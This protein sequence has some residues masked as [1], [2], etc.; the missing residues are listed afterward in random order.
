MPLI[1]SVWVRN[2]KNQTKGLGK[3]PPLRGQQYIQQGKCAQESLFF[4]WIVSKRQAG[5]K[6]RRGHIG[7]EIQLK[8][9]GPDLNT[10]LP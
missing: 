4:A 2:P 8:N 10:L 7:E 6:V 3:V 1:L 9:R 5:L